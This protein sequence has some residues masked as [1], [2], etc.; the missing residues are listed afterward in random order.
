MSRCATIAVLVALWA[1]LGC[2]GASDDTPEAKATRA[3]A[4]QTK[5]RDALL[6]R[7]APEM[8]QA[9]PKIDLNETQRPL[10]TQALM[11]EL[12]KPV[13]Q[14]IVTVG[15]IRVDMKLGRIE[16][17]AKVALDQGV[18]EYLLVTTNGKAYESVFTT[19]V[20]ALHLQLALLMAGLQESSAERKS[21][22]D[23]VKLGLRFR[24]P[25]ATAD[26]EVS[27]NECLLDRSSGKA[28]SNI[29]W[30]F[31]GS[32]ARSGRVWASLTGSMIAL[33]GDASAILNAAT[34]VGNPYAG[35]NTGVGV[36]TSA[37]PAVGTAVTLIISKA[38]T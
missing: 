36:N 31:T 6:A 19:D 30:N 9:A 13:S 33:R 26:S 11:K 18:L 22:G 8:M 5:I 29:A 24:K 20:P 27:A 28:V 12:V 34:D 21:P 25:G 37:V 3:L 4:E 38:S 17:P 7:G 35:P 16:M 10:D 15:D 32:P 1:V 23:V 14:D 2:Q